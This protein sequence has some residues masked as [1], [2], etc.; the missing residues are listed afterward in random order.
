MFPSFQQL[1]DCSLPRVVF[2][3]SEQTNLGFLLDVRRLDVT[4]LEVCRLE[5]IFRDVLRFLDVTRLDVILR[6]V[7]RR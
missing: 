1:F 2:R 4:L 3:Q 5:V 7:I 6:D